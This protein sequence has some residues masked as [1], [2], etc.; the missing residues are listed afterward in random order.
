MIGRAAKAGLRLGGRAIKGGFK[1]AGRAG[2]NTAA[3]IAGETT[4]VGRGTLSGN[5]GHGLGESLNIL[6]GGVAKGAGGLAKGAIRGTPG[7]AADIAGTAAGA[8]RVLDRGFRE[9][10]RDIFNPLGREM[11]PWAKAGV[12]GG[13]LGAAGVMGMRD[14]ETRETMNRVRNPR[15]Q[16]PSMLEQTGRSPQQ[17]HERPRHAQDLGA[18]GDLVHALHNMR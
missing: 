5:L 1:S 7:A 18:T 16:N 11:K 3:G 2:I 14:M 4:S 6:G 15:V 12:I 10:P 13:A 9:A 17:P 8:K